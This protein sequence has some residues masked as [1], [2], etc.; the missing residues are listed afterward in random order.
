MDTKVVEDRVA[1]RYRLMAGGKEVGFVEYDPIGEDAVLLK[2]TEVG[3]E[4]E[5]KGYASKLLAGMLDDLR[6]RGMSVL[7]V[8]PYAMSYIR[9][10]R[11]YL[12]VVRN[13]YRAAV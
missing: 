5:G 2:H 7:P 8:C 12:D 11:E 9:K 3:P 13:D 10:H 4:H 1:Q 6:K